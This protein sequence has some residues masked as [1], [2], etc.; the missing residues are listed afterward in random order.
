[1]LKTTMRTKKLLLVP[2]EEKEE[3]QDLWHQKGSQGCLH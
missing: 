2:A 3:G 1:M